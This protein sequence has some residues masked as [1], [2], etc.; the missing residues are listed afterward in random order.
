MTDERVEFRSP[1]ELLV[2]FDL[3][4][5]GMFGNRTEA[6]LALMRKYVEGA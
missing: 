5:K 1:K 4:W 6:L 2:K 3:K